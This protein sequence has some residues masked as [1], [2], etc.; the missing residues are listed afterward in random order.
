MFNSNSTRHLSTSRL[1]ECTHNNGTVGEVCRIIIS[2]NPSL[3]TKMSVVF[4][5]TFPPVLYVTLSVSVT[6][7]TV[8]PVR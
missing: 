1:I 7:T 3:V 8:I 2:I 6:K 4:T 5:I